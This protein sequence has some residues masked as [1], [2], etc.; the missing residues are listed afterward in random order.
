MRQAGILAAAAI[1]A[2]DH[3]VD[4]L[5][6]DHANARFLAESIA[7]LKG[8]EI[9]MANVQTNMVIA[10]VAQSGRSQG[11]ILRLLSDG[12]VLLTPERHS[13]IRAVTH[14]NVSREDVVRAC[15]VFQSVF[16]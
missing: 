16:R 10:D 4:R 7:G 9:E 8:L 1:H 11:E 13:S 6:E 12:G 3:H 15:G 2:L 14:L 5:A